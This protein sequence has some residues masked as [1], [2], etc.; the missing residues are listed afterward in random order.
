MCN[1]L[2][3]DD[4]VYEQPSNSFFKTTCESDFAPLYI[5]SWFTT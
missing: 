4:I 1:Y 3:F 5:L 2:S